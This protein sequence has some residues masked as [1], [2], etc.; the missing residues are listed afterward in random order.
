M[1]SHRILLIVRHAHREKLD[2]GSAD[3]GLSPKGLKQAR[4]IRRWFKKNFPTRV[5]TVVS[6]PKLRCAET[7]EPL[8]QWLGAQVRTESFLDEGGSLEVK[9]AQLER[10]WLNQKSAITVMCS[11]GDVIPVA[12]HRLTGARA[13]LSKGAIATIEETPDGIVLSELIQE[14]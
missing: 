5:A 7:V 2:G 8:A 3:N 6:S 10:F 9:A 1:K 14:P 4:A 12:L 13:S 11:H